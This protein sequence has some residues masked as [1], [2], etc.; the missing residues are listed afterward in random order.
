VG[1]KLGGGLMPSAPFILQDVPAD[2]G[3]S[4]RILAPEIVFGDAYFWSR[5]EGDV[6]ACNPISVCFISA[7]NAFE[8]T[9]ASPV[10][11]ANAPAPWAGLACVAGLDFFNEYAFF[12]SYAF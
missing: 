12:F 7:F 5:P 3:I 11:L 8:V 4:L 10:L 9:V 1:L 6:E 2:G